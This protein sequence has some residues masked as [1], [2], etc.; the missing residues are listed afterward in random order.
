MTDEGKT[1][2][3]LLAKLEAAQRRVVELEASEAQVKSEAVKHNRAEEKLA[4]ALVHNPVPTA[5][6]GADGS[7]VSFNEA[8][9]RLIGYTTDEIATVNQWAEK[10]YPDPEYRAFVVENI[11]QALHGKEQETTEFEVTCKDGSKKTLDFKTSFFPD[12]LIIQML[13]ITEPKRAEAALRDR[14]ATFAGTVSGRRR[15]SRGASSSARAL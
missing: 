13:D 11:G 6:G 7:V 12:G 15:P 9:V 10:L 4:A 8:L 14:A 5:V 1:R 2:E 3:Q